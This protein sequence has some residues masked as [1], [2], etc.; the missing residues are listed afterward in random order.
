MQPRLLKYNDVEYEPQEFT[1]KN[2]SGWL[3]VGDRVLVLSDVV[4][5]QTSG[6]VFITEDMAARMDASAYTGVVVQIGLD[7]FMWNSDRTRPFAGFRPEIGARVTFEKFAGVLVPG[8]DGKIYRLMD[9]KCI[10][11]VEE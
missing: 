11:G 10:G 8:I 1:G 9:D 3:P 7:A 5:Q 6:G 4:R 2:E